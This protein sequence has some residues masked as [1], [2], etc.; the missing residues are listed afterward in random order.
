MVMIK[1]YVDK[2]CYWVGTPYYILSSCIRNR[3]VRV[4]GVDVDQHGH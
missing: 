3:N 2:F 1:L 4:V